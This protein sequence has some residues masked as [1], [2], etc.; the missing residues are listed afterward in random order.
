MLELIDVEIR[1][2]VGIE[3]A[4]TA[5]TYVDD[6]ATLQLRHV[7]LSGNTVFTASP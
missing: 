7:A 2:N 5:T 4:L 3:N 1:D 6:S